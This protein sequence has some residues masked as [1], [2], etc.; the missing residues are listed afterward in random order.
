MQNNLIVA[1]LRRLQSWPICHWGQNISSVALVK[2]TVSTQLSTQ[3]PVL[4]TV[5][6]S[7]SSPTVTDPP[8]ITIPYT[9]T[10]ALALAAKSKLQN[11]LPRGFACDRV[12]ELQPE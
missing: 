4:S 3:L 12:T 8:P 11:T 1:P 6:Y 9:R 5:Q 10:I 7:P 2:Q